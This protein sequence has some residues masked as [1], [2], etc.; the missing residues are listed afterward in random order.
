[1][2]ALRLLGGF[3]VRV[4]GRTLEGLRSSRARE[5]L[6]YLVLH[7]EVAHVRGRLAFLF[8][9][10]SSEEQARTNLRNVLHLLRSAHEVLDAS[11]HVTSTTLQWRPV[12]EVTVDVERFLAAVDIAIATGPDQVDTFIDCCRTAVGLYA[13]ELLGGVDGEWLIPWR[14]KLRENHR[15]V[16]TS[17]ATALIDSGRPG[18]A[19]GIVRQLVLTDPLDEAAHRLLIEAHVRAGDRARAMRAYHECVATLERELA[20][21]P[22]RATL[23]L[24]ESLLG[25]ERGVGTSR[26]D[27]SVGGLRR[28][29]GR[30]AELAKL[31]SAWKDAQSGPPSVL[32]ISGEAGIGKSRLVEELLARCAASGA[33]IGAARS[34]ATEGDLG[35]GVVTSWLRSPDIARGRSTLSERELGDLARL[36]PELPAEASAEAADEPTRRRRLFDA[37][38]AAL[39]AS[40]RPTLL[41]ADDAQWSDQ[42]SYELIHYAVRAGRSAPLLV[43]LTA[44]TED[45]DSG[46]PLKSLLD[47]LSVLD[48][49]TEIGLDRLP[50]AAIGEL[51]TQLIGSPLSDD[52][53]HALFA[54]SEG[55]PLFVVETIRGGW[56]GR[57]AP[58][59]LTPRLRAVIDARFRQLSDPAVTLLRS[60]AVVGRPSSAALLKVV[61]DLDERS[62]VRGLDELWQRGILYE[63]GADAYEFSHGKLRDAAYDALTPASRRAQ[64]GAVAD[65]LVQLGE[66]E[67]DA[68]ASHAAVHFEAA[69]RIDEAVYW[70]QR[71]A[72]DAQRSF[73]HGE[74]V[75]LLERALALVP[76]LPSDVRHSRELELLSTLPAVLA[77]VDGYGTVRMSDAHRRAADVAA[78]LGVELEPAFVRSMVMSTLCRDEFAEAAATA[79]RLLARAEADRDVGLRVESHYL[80]GICAF[81]S[82]DLVAARRHFEAVLADFDP[83][84]RSEHQAVYGHDPY[85]VCLSRLA[86]TL[87]FL[88]RDDDAR[89]TC[90]AALAIAAEV[91]H[92]LSHDTAAI[93]AC[94][95]AVDLGDHEL[96][97]RCTARL[98]AL[99]MD[100]LP[101]LT[102]REALLG[103][104]DVVDGRHEVGIARIFAA[105][106]ECDGRN[107]YPGFRATIARVLLAAY[108]VAGDGAGGLSAVER[109]LGLGGTPLWE[110]E[111]YRLRAVFLRRVVAD[112]ADT[113]AALSAAERVAHRQRA[114]G[115]LR[116]ID[117][118]RRRLIGDGQP[119]RQV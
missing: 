88:G 83:S 75:R 60:A 55:N 42:A 109:A 77:G 54:E 72:I 38:V 21:E 10:D 40:G 49:M 79:A 87:W 90:D 19:A 91:A 6:A 66:R 18:E 95:L 99:G 85:V 98:G 119:A 106:D 44:R 63:S 102:K 25:S 65:A 89:R 3:Q 26:R 97:R 27:P 9:P 57:I 4:G 12:Q 116:R 8:W 81:W 20:V 78:G 115:H 30:E 84:A 13:G 23:A 110:A 52:A 67:P 34:Y 24:Y 7:P 46:H 118:T 104:L 58:V 59:A 80:L 93:F 5:L 73:A 39:T 1:M 100:S 112:E 71:A 36:L 2:L 94:L 111:A 53:V 47:A 33:A 105:L 29:V 103:L 117:E 35:H 114:A 68:T 14:E 48:R 108:A 92:P 61:S 16:L 56:D 31:L 62:V 15:L 41:I 70:F 37:A 82:A 113:L 28:L 74:A 17:L 50:V 43:V 32:L 76:A 22:S 96:L 86:N 101:H 64:H 45:L 69:L 11:L 107:F 51:G